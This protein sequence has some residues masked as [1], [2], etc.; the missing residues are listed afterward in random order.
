LLVLTS[1][2]LV[3]FLIYSVPN[4][5][6]AKEARKV[7]VSESHTIDYNKSPY[8][9]VPANIGSNSRYYGWIFI[10]FILPVLTGI[11]SCLIGILN[12]L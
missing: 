9:I 7:I 8:S 10:H 12:I 2:F 5:R 3:A 11:T 1:Y 6:D 4:Y